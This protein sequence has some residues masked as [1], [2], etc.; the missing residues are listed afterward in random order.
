MIDRRHKKLFVATAIALSLL[1]IA[2]FTLGICCS[3]GVFGEPFISVDLSR[4]YQTVDGFGASSAWRYQAFGLLDDDSI[5]DEAMDLL[6]GD[7]GLSMNIF[8]YNVGGGGVESD[9]YWDPQ[10]GAESFFVAEAFDGDYSV[11]NDTSNYDFTRD[12]GVRDLFERALSLGNIEKVVFFA[13]SPHYLM[14]RNGKTHADVPKQNNLKEECYEAFSN[15]LIIITDWLYKNIV[16]AYDPD[17]EIFISPIN[18]PQWSWGGDDASQEGC[19]YDAK[20]LAEFCDV[21][22]RTLAEFNAANSANYK[23]DIFESGSYELSK[24]KPYLKEL[25]RYDWFKEID[26]I[27]VHS[28]HGDLSAYTK[29]SFKNYMDKNFA[30][31]N[32]SMSEYCILTDG[33]DESIDTGL[34]SAK[35]MLR[36]LYYFNATEW[37]WWLSISNGDYEDG[38]VYWNV[39]GDGNDF[40]R[41]TKRYYTFKQ[42]SAF[43]TGAT[44]VYS[45][46][47]N[48]KLIDADFDQIAFKNTDGNLVLIAINSGDK[49]KR[50][51]LDGVTPKHIAATVTD[52]NSDFETKECD[53]D[54][55]LRV[56][57][58]S[59]STYVIEI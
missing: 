27:F 51:R 43:A 8:R 9:S 28:Y 38:L 47:G 53:F 25:S 57:A 16:C 29:R 20:P 40:L 50:V 23:L 33:V 13:N 46:Y 12:E 18:E 10:R 36:D 48:N 55:Y 15:Y 32:I 31:K 41:M 59:I 52:A 5:K 3:V 4:E 30:G 26:T 37:S 39:D 45:K 22:Y 58:K 44:R 14:T 24:I 7:D 17:I 2:S 35:V 1:L 49:E 34:Y 21:F 54:G 56:G 11:F 42:F 6:Y 19:H